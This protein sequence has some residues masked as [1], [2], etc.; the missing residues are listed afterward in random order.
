MI[1][2][3]Y[4]EIAIT[5][6]PACE[7][8]VTDVL[9]SSFD[10]EGV[11]T[12]TEEFKDLESI[13]LIDNIVK[14]FFV[15]EKNLSESEIK[16][17]IKEEYNNLLSNGCSKEYLGDWSVNIRQVENEDW[18]KKWK[19]NWTPTK[20]TEKITICP[21]W[22]D[23]KKQEK[24]LVI[25]IDPGAAFGTG[26]HPTTKL[27]VRALEKY[28]ATGD[29]V[30][31]IGTGT[32]ILAITAS[33]LGANDVVAIDNDG[34][35]VKTAIEN[36]EINNVTNCTFSENEIYAI[37]DEFDFVTANIL[38]NVLAEIMGELK[39]IL[40]PQGKVVLSGILNTKQDVVLDA[41]K[42]HDLEI[43]ELTEEEQ[44]VAIITK[45]RG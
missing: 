43:V 7:E 12:S 14:G 41:I 37:K 13:N 30:A 44:W 25:S 15:N 18:S 11:V 21:S 8:L 28:M 2:K 4:L 23:Y 39:R 19:E 3:E 45:K 6:N 27:C 40:K 10:C 35:A 24:E 26:V 1:E 32:G 5:I 29:K 22:I 17:I 42:Q 9:F 16:K 38:H 34:V 36:A 33:M 31:D 20:I